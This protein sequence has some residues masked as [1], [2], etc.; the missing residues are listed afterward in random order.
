MEYFDIVK[1][2]FPWIVN[3]LEAT[4]LIQAYF[5]QYEINN[6]IKWLLSCAFTCPKNRYFTFK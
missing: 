4:G 5:F 3:E 2:F 1:Y 6:G